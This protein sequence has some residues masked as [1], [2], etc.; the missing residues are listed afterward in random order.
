MNS[1][2]NL[3]KFF[4]EEQKICKL[5]VKVLMSQQTI[6]TLLPETKAVTEVIE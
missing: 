1:H 6:F 4:K 2:Q 5:P 3:S